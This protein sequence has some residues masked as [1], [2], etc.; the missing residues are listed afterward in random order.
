MSEKIHLAV[1][2]G[3]QSAEHE[4][5]IASAH[6]V[7]SALNATLYQVGVIYIDHQGSWRWFDDVA[8]FMCLPAQSAGLVDQGLPVT[9]NFGQDH[10]ALISTTGAQQRI[11]VDCFVPILHGTLGED[12]A[13]QGVFE[14][15]G[16]A[17]VGADVLASAACMDKHIAKQIMQASGL[18][19]T[20]WVLLS[21]EEAAQYPY[22]ELVEELGEVLFVKPANLGSSIG[23][24]KV[25]TASEYRHAVQYAL[26]Y[27]DKILIEPFIDA[28]EIECSVLGNEDLT[29]SLP[30]EIV[31]QNGF[32]S[33]DAKYI[34]AD[35]AAVVTPAD[36]PENVIDMIQDL[37]LAACSALHVEGMARVDF[38]VN[39]EAILINEVNTIPGFTNISMYPKNWEVSG[40]SAGDLLDE[41]I[42]LAFA[43]RKK[44]AALLRLNIP[45]NS[46]TG[47]D[48]QLG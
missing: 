28:R 32:Y 31:L 1:V 40:L 36:L 45:S 10:P 30:G 20:D 27:D 14:M 42:Q 22:T 43:R 33:F 25:A 19:V 17:Y 34:D 21:R 16:A 47:C 3:G 15:L 12:G 46:Q 6:N 35:A 26:K 37:S 8:Q 2:C 18:P 23:I 24:S 11:H 5:S 48:D 38:F 29:V 39:E 44:Q 13:I 41:L 7:I 4:V 9:V